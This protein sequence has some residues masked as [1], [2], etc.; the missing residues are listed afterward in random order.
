MNTD[1]V[2]KKFEHN[3][4]RF[5]ER[6]EAAKKLV[7]ARYPI[8]FIIAPI[9]IY[10]NWERDY[11]NLIKKLSVSIGRE[12]ED[13]SFELIQHRFTQRAKERILERFPNT[14]LDMDE[15][16]RIKKWGKYGIY[17]YV[18][19]KDVSEK[20]KESFSKWIEQYFSNGHIEYFT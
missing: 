16:H 9:I 5:D 15:E 14:K 19:E 8:G 13:I 7:K 2:I 3:T 20:M 4:S 1:Y 10:D 12:T 11:Q 17:K 6:L 18:Y